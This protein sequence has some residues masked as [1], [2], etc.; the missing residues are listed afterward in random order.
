V[1]IPSG[2]VAPKGSDVQLLPPKGAVSKS[3][4]TILMP[5]MKERGVSDFTAWC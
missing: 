2:V 3:G 4:V 1:D 5:T